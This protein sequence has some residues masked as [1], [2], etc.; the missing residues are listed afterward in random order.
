MS[1]TRSQLAR[2]IAN[3]T[4]NGATLYLSDRS[5][6]NLV[7]EPTFDSI[8]TG[9]HGRIDEVVKSRVYKIPLTLWGGWESLSVIFPSFLTNPVM[10]DSVFGSSDLPLVVQ[11]KSG[12]KITFAN[13]QITKLGDLFLGVDAEIWAAA[14]EMTAIIAD[15]ANPEDSGAYYTI[16]TGTYSVSGF[17]RGN[18][19]RQR[20]TGAWGAITGWTSFVAQKGI[21]VNWSCDLQPL[22]VDGYDVRDFTVGPKTVM[23]SASFIPIGPT[24]AQVKSNAFSDATA[25]GALASSKAAALVLTGGSNSVTLNQAFLAKH[26]ESFGATPLIV[27]ECT[28]RTVRGLTSGAATAVAAVA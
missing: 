14:V 11:A 24:D 21:K 2:S 17:T 1:L 23:A 15:G 3:V 6:L 20:W 10:G 12:K 28:F 18:Y 26:Q 7:F 4:W 25:L 16:G 9:S 5:D 27:N 22:A 13:A 19:N 8:G